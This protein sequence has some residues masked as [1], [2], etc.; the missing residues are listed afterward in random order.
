MS[1]KSKRS[2]YK[3]NMIKQQRKL[4]KERKESQKTDN[5]TNL[6][7]HQ[8]NTVIESCC[9]KVSDPNINNFYRSNEFR[10]HMSKFD[11]KYVNINENEKIS[12]L[13]TVIDKAKGGYFK[14][15]SSDK[16][17]YILQPIC[18]IDKPAD[19][20]KQTIYNEIETIIGYIY[21][22][23]RI[24][25]KD[26]EFC[27]VELEDMVAVAI[28]SSQPLQRLASIHSEIVFSSITHADYLKTENSTIA[29]TNSGIQFSHKIKI[30]GEG[31]YFDESDV[32]FTN[33]EIT[34]ETSSDGGL[35]LSMLSHYIDNYLAKWYESQLEPTKV[36][37]L[38]KYL[39]SANC[40]G[41]IKL[42]KTENS[43]CYVQHI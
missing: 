38:T 9:T 34:V 36:E 41:L 15:P 18:T 35:L 21:R 12:Y 26:L 1:K 5:H 43:L 33:G 32:T 6:N 10:E 17:T 37:T 31:R 19:Y 8:I 30:I 13:T 25:V 28:R 23:Y 4:N 24:G 16:L 40:C 7:S 42:I 14:D 3:R 2:K 20:N 39:M 22:D 11:I 29:K 27:Y